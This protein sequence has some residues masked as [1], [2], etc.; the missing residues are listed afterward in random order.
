MSEKTIKGRVIV[1]HDIEDCWRLQVDFVPR[2]GEIIVYDPD[3]KYGFARFKIGDGKTKVNNLPF[4]SSEDKYLRDRVEYL[5]GEVE[6]IND[7]LSKLQPKEDLNLKTEDKTIVGAI[8]EL[9][10]RPASTGEHY[11][12]DCN[13][14][15][16]TEK[17]VMYVNMADEV[18][19]KTLPISAAAVS[20]TVGNIEA[21]L[22]KI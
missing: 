19:D 14:L 16:V 21:L 7:K 20:K 13:T 2:R 11:V 22:K 6:Q 17:K 3:K 10:E 15:M 1:T 12:P 9:Y 18:E 5:G 8:N 4:A